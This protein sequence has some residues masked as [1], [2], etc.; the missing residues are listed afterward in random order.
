MNIFEQ[1]KALS[2]APFYFKEVGD[3][4]Q[5]TYIGKRGMDENGHYERDN[6]NNEIITYEL[7]VP[8]GIA[9]VA[10]TITKKINDDMN[11]V[12]FG[13][14]IGF[15]HTGMQS[16]K[17]KRTGKISEFKNIKVFADPKIV[18]AEWLAM[19][20]GVGEIVKPSKEGI[21]TIDM[22]KKNQAN[23]N[24][25]TANE[26]FVSES[27]SP[28]AKLKAITDL[29]KD[30]LG[31]IDPNILKDKVMEFT[32]L[33]FLEINYMAIIKSLESK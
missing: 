5:G 6:F 7:Q 14:I 27:S 10:F 3:E 17:D 15:K 32:G 23:F 16:Y 28:E 12:K 9:E 18:D 20:E 19:N 30:K 26:P 24:A 33:A 8:D 2:V 31:V 29:A 22:D 1:G 13:Q 21:E 11:H 4:I 25:M